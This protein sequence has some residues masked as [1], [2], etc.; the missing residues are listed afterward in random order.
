[1]PEERRGK[2]RFAKQIGGWGSFADVEVVV[3]PRN[4]NSALLDVG[5]L[6]D[7]PRGDD[8]LAGVQFGVRYALEHVP[9][10]ERNVS[11]RVP[12]LH[13]N[14][15]DSSTLSVA[16]AT[17]FAVWDALGHSPDAAPYFD[18]ASKSFVFPR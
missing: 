7:D 14:P 10:S 5:G 1:M 16:F 11:I 3:S 12:Y 4:S 15:V 2:H 18:D 13:T 9:G 6:S 8:W 17:C